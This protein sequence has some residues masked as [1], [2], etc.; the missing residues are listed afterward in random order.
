MSLFVVRQN[1]DE[2]EDREKS[3]LNTY[4]FER[5]ILMY[6]QFYAKKETAYD[7]EKKPKT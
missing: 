5:R 3:Y 2:V 4:Y 1:I 6:L 7:Y